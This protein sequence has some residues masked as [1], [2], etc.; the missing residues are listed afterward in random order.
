M[1]INK[2]IG[3]SNLEDENK[4][5]REVIQHLINKLGKH[6]DKEYSRIDDVNEKAGVDTD[7]EL[8][9]ILSGSEL[10]N[11]VIK[12]LNL[13]T[14]VDI[15][16]E[17]VNTSLV[18]SFRSKAIKYPGDIDM[19]EFYNVE[20]ENYND[21]VNKICNELKKVGT[22]ISNNRE[23]IL[24]DFK[25]GFDK[26][27]DNLMQN[28]GKL[29]MEYANPDMIEYFEENIQDYNYELCKANLEEL[30]ANG[31][32]NEDTVK[33]IYHLLPKNKMT[34][35]AYLDIFKVIRKFRLLRWTLSEIIEGVKVI[36]SRNT[37]NNNMYVVKLSDAVQHQTITKLDLWAKVGTRWTEITNI[38]IFKYKDK[39]TGNLIPIGFDFKVSIDEATEID[40]KYYSSEEH[41][42]PFKLA[43][44]IWNRAFGVVGHAINP[45]TKKVEE[46]KIDP[47]QFYIMKLLFPL[48]SADINKISQ[49]LADLE[50]LIT[51]LEK[52]ELLNLTY[53]LLYKDLLVNLENM[54]LELFRIIILPN[55]SV[56]QEVTKKINDILNYINSTFNNNYK[57]ID[58]KKWSD[59]MNTDFRN[60][61]IE[62]LEEIMKSLKGLQEFY[63][64][65]YLIANKLHPRYPNSIIRYKYDFNYLNLPIVKL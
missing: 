39:Q 14:I 48:F 2:L 1:K 41:E 50:L 47:T 63:A 6:T 60:N 42:K 5:L 30:Y 25:C 16:K 26:R 31:A 59:V 64:K 43:K 17:S 61:L 24:A 46:N 40:I 27:F 10:P 20:A 28:L 62:K 58:D 49:V 32:I 52:M 57:N 36:K 45:E 33:S 9:E 55:K 53:T 29:K 7:P 44:R 22:D 13:L 11:D 35:K 21:A 65:T 4:E 38:F 54:P 51:S 37:V 23:V 19:L 8:L 15:N 12:I 18:G 3:G 56:I 34:G